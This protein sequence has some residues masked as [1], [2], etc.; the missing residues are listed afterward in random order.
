MPSGPGS[1]KF[2]LLFA[3]M[4][5]GKGN[6]SHI[7]PSV[8]AERLYI[9]DI[10]LKDNAATSLEESGC[11]NTYRRSKGA[12]KRVKVPNLAQAANRSCWLLQ[13]RGGKGPSFLQYMPKGSV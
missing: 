3:L 9:I 11:T 4:G 10:G 7:I 8:Y 6:G 2:D 12:L 13:E 1:P 5:G